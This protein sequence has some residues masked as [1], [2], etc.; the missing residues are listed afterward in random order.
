VADRTATELELLG[1]V[2]AGLARYDFWAPISLVDVRLEGESAP[3]LA[4]IVRS[5]DRPGEIFGLTTVLS[6]WDF[7]GGGLR[8]PTTQGWA[9]WIVDA[10]AEVV[11]SDNGLPVSSPDADGVTWITLD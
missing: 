7:P 8:Q 10:I 6:E 1:W 11:D 9:A 3:R 2:S 4:V 5:G